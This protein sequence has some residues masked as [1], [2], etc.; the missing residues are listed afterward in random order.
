MFRVSIVFHGSRPLHL[1]DP[2]DADDGGVEQG[3]DSF[4]VVDV[5]RIA[6]AHEDD[7]RW[8]PGQGTDC[9]TAGCQI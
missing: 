7:V 9:H 2:F 3:A 4:L 5:V 1:N 8:Q 6:Y